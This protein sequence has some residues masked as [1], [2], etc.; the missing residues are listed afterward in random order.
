STGSPPSPYLLLLHQLLHPSS[1]LP[2]PLVHHLRRGDGGGAAN[3]RRDLDLFLTLR[4]S[5]TAADVR[6]PPPLRLLPPLRRTLGDG[7]GCEETAS[8]TPL[9]VQ[10]WSC[11]NGGG[12]LIM[13]VFSRWWV[14]D[15]VMVWWWDRTRRKE[16]FV[17]NSLPF[18]F[19]R[20]SFPF[21]FV[22][23]FCNFG[24]YIGGERPSERPICV[25]AI[26]KLL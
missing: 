19:C 3:R 7:D 26:R 13:V 1:L 10:D 22:P 6:K 16:K 8:P 21:F 18:T 15:K 9:F 17:G 4:L 12:V 20:F 24:S 14:D 11:V 2:H 23:I 25:A 5:T